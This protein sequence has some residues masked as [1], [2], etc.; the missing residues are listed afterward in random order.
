MP[1]MV[2]VAA[3]A[4]LDVTARSSL[5]T[6]ALAVTAAWG[7]MAL[8]HMALRLSLGLVPWGRGRS[9]WAAFLMLGW[10]HLLALAGWFAL[11]LLFPL[12]PPLLALFGPALL[13][14]A[15]QLLGDQTARRLLQHS[16][17]VAAD[18]LE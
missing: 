9:A 5:A 13:V 11:A 4:T 15:L 14:W 16:G 2:T 3:V 8:S 1:I 7:A 10:W 6:A 17:K 18:G 12:S